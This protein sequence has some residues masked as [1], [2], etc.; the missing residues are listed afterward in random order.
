LQSQQSPTPH[1]S[2][3]KT[4]RLAIS[5]VNKIK[6]NETYL[7]ARRALIAASPFTFIGHWPDQ[8]EGIAPK[9]HFES[10]NTS[11]FWLGTARMLHPVK[12]Q[13]QPASV[14]MVKAGGGRGL[15]RSQGWAARTHKIAA[16][17]LTCGA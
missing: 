3:A 2:T 6:M 1:P 17:P 15:Q 14:V 8:H 10:R 5:D 16:F 11:A 13:L 4:L 12:S 9:G 7:I